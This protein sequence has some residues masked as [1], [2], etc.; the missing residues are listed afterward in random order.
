[1][2]WYTT[3]DAHRDAERQR[4]QRESVGLP[5]PHCSTFCAAGERCAITADGRCGA[6]AML[7]TAPSAES[8]EV[9]DKFDDA[10]RLL[11]EIAERETT[12]PEPGSVIDRIDKFLATHKA[13]THQEPQA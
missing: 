7:A 1:M 2:S 3:A 9:S 11:E 13:T 4:Q 6:L 5:S 12:E 8:G 10:V